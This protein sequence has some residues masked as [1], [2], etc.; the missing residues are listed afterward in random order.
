[1]KWIRVE[2]SRTAQPKTGNYRQWKPILANEGRHQCVY[3]AIPESRFGGTWNFHVE[4]YRPR[5]RFLDLENTIGNLFYSCAICNTFKGDDWPNEPMLTHR[6]ASYP[7]ASRH[8]YNNLF[9][10]DIGSGMIIGRY[11]A[12]RY[13][14]EKLYLNRPQLI[15]E[16]REYWIYEEFEQLVEW[17]RQEGSTPSRQTGKTRVVLAALTQL[18]LETTSLIMKGRKAIPYDATAVKRTR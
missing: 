14:V 16:R 11:T 13:M 4:H 15:L 18:A 10:I 12:S 17:L 5:A 6:I 9:N 8:D 3:C 2:K 7:D 1:M